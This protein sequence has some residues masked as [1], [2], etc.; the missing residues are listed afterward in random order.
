MEICIWVPCD[1]QIRMK[2]KGNFYR[3]S[4]LPALLYG[5]KCWVSKQVHIDNM[6]VAEM[7]MLRWMC[8][9]PLKAESLTTSYEHN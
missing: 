1:K 7:R 9:K 8:G 4:I 3:T 5:I 2:L 6:R